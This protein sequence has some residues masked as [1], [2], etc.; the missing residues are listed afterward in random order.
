MRLLKQR[1]QLWT[2]FQKKRPRLA[3]CDAA[4]GS[5]IYLLN[6][7]LLPAVE[8]RWR[9]RWISI[10]RTCGCRLGGRACGRALRNRERIEE[11]RSCSADT[12]SHESPQSLYGNNL[13]G[14]RVRP[15]KIARD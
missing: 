10:V 8:T 4:G 6:G 7:R 5:V 11:G 15:A 12:Q 1:K 2:E 14:S 13:P 3:G 9:Q